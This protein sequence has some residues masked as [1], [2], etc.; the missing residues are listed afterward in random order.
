MDY[1]EIF[2]AFASRYV[3]P[4]LRGRFVHEAS[5]KPDKLYCRVCHNIDKLVDVSLVN[6]QCNFN[7]DD[8][9]IVLS[10]FR[11][12]QAST[13]EQIKK[14]IGLGNGMLVIGSRGVKFYAETESA[15][16]VP[17]VAYAAGR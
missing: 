14:Q 7:D 4:E 5:K 12:F 11:G 13:W 16:G 15:K 8:E 1:T 10:G 2:K 3:K 6:G 9:C 17:S